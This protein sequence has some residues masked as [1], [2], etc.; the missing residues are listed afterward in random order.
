M[1]VRL[2]A[3]FEV[4]LGVAVIAAAAGGALGGDDF[5]QPEPRMVLEELHEALADGAGA[6]E[7]RDR[8]AVGSRGARGGGVGER[9]GHR[10][11][12]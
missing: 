11:G 3:A 8:D 9:C 6:A 12:F 10:Q 7:N 5:V 1:L 2:D 4:A